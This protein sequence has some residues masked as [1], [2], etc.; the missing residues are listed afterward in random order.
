MIPLR[1]KVSRKILSYYFLNPSK[2]HYINE[3]ARL[4]ELDPKNL[5]SKLVEFE[6]LGIFCS[7]YH[8]KERFFFLNKTFPLLKAYKE[9]VLN[10]GGLEVSLRGALSLLSGLKEAYIFGSYAKGNMD[11]HSDIDLLAIGKHSSL[12]LQKLVS[13]IKK[14]SGRVINVVSLTEKE[15]ISRKKKHDPLVGDI[16][17]GK[18]IRLL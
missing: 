11:E 5:H 10:I 9:I 3:L 16:F 2:R 17:N 1:S 4:L 14:S 8:G 7:E 6:R 13:P 18:V 15:Y 12:E